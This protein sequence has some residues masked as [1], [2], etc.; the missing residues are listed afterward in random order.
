MVVFM[1]RENLILKRARLLDQ[2]ES[3]LKEDD[4]QSLSEI[5]T[6]IAKISIKLGDENMTNFLIDNFPEIRALII[7]S[8]APFEPEVLLNTS[9]EEPS[10]E[11]DSLIDQRRTASGN[12]LKCGIIPTVVKNDREILLEIIT[13]NLPY[14]SDK[15]KEHAVERLLKLPAGAKRDAYL[16]VFL[17][18]NRQYATIDPIS[19]KNKLEEKKA[20]FVETSQ[21]EL[22]GAIGLFDPF[23]IIENLNYKTLNY[24]LSKTNSI[25]DI[26][27]REE[28]I[29]QYYENIQLSYNQIPEIRKHFPNPITY[30][31]HLLHKDPTLTHYFEKFD[32]LSK[33]E[34]IDIFADFCADNQITVYDLSTNPSIPWD[35]YLSKEEPGTKNGVALFLGGFEIIEKFEETLEKLRNG[36]EYYNWIILITSPLGVL[37]IG[38]ERL[39]NDMEKLGASVYIIDP[40]RGIIYQLLK[41]KDSSKITKEKGK[42]LFHPTNMPL[43]HLNPQK[44]ISEYTFDT[45]FHQKPSN[46]LLFGLNEYPYRQVDFGS[47]ERDKNNIQYL[48]ILHKE[49]G[50]CL[51]Y[52]EWVHESL[53]PDLVSGLI[54]AI[55]NFGNNFGEA[56]GLQE[57]QYSGFTITFADG[58]YIKACLFL[59]EAP[60][61]RLKD[62]INVAV[63]RWEAFFEQ[64][65]KNFRGSLQPYVEKNTEIIKHLNQIF[66]GE[67][68]Q[69]QIDTVIQVLP[70]P[71]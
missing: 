3:Y 30:L 32:I 1:D 63:N 34:M 57:I 23:Q 2:A 53:D 64:D 16:K 9:S 62:L 26:S 28:L 38:L 7:S 8:E 17:I 20:W 49:K 41:S 55:D 56:K 6:V 71:V 14:I 58:Q 27:L 18:K 60:S 47:I 31:G 4:F 22:K 36:T 29:L 45:K 19:I 48:I 33:H 24:L 67:I 21:R 15:D 25:T 59:K 54:T 65:I 69:F 13:E 68:N 43:R 66:L 10:S 40:V 37:K 42:A 5:L 50:V 61:H 52:L 35:L 51:S 44:S 11:P 12:A 70:L 39:R 46:F